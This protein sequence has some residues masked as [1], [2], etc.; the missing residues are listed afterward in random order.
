[1]PHRAKD[2]L[3][4]LM[5][6]QETCGVGMPVEVVEDVSLC[7]LKQRLGRGPVACG[8]GGQEDHTKLALALFSHNPIVSQE[9]NQPLQAMQESVQRPKVQRTCELHI[10]AR[11]LLPLSVI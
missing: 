5:H 2:C 8:D 6:S 9:P 10:A 3:H 11:F 7:A 4:R 1:M